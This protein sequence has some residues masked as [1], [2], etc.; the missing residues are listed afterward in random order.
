MIGVLGFGAQATS[1]DIGNNGKWRIDVDGNVIPLVSG[2]LTLGEDGATFGEGDFDA[3]FLCGVSITSWGSAFSPWETVGT[4]ARLI[5]GGD[6]IKAYHNGNFTI[7]G[8]YTGDSYI[9][10][11]SAVWDNA[12]NNTVTLTE[13]S[14]V[15]SLVFDGTDVAF[16]VDSGGLTVKLTDS[17]D[18]TF[19]I[20][21]KN[22]STDYLSIYQGANQ[23]II[24]ALGTGNDLY[25]I[26]AGGDINFADEN[27]TGTGDLSI[28]GITCTSL[29]GITSITFVDDVLSRSADDVLRWASNDEDSTFE[30][31]GFTAKDAIL[32][33]IAD[34]S[35]HNGDEYKLMVD[36]TDQQLE[37]HNDSS[38]SHVQIFAWDTTGN[39]IMEADR[40]TMGDDE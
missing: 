14:S 8:D 11:N 36:D 18:G 38:G 9:M 5:S 31:Y 28:G 4:Y 10:E 12:A 20:Y 23:A 37:I 16:D 30:I 27:L 22:V 26:A 24:S 1:T 39:I 29:T 35:G 25:L 17:S 33:L 15:L 6:N 2:V 21:T 13:N 3:L 7:V 34:A 19:D 40:I 32:L